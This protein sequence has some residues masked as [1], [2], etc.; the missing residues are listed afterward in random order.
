VAEEGR[1]LAKAAV[2]CHCI[3]WY[4]A[5]DES[6]TR[7]CKRTRLD[8]RTFILFFAGVD[9]NSFADDRDTKRNSLL[10]IVDYVDSMGRQAF[11]EVCRP[12]A[13]DTHLR[14]NVEHV[15]TRLISVSL[16]YRIFEDTVT[17]VRLNLFRSLPVAPE[18]KGDPDEEEQVRLFAC[19]Q[20]Y[21]ARPRA[22]ETSSHVPILRTQVKHT[23]TRTHSSTLL[24][25]V[26]RRCLRILNGRT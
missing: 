3:R 26:Y 17:M 20:T 25:C 9:P 19:V 14:A 22:T 4:A 11:S 10:E 1:L 24:S 8:S 12:A 6:S 18:A 16:Q 13:L 23:C 5:C 2:V 7:H 15:C 21:L